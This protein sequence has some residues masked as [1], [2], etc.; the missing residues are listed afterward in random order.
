MVAIGNY[1]DLDRLST[2]TLD[3][4]SHDVRN[5]SSVTNNSDQAV[6]LVNSYEKSTTKYQ[7]VG[8]SLV[9]TYLGSNGVSLVSTNL[10]SCDIFQFSYYQRNPTNSFLFITNSSAAQVKL[11]SVS[12]RCSRH[13][14]NSTLNTES[15]QT[16]NV[17]QRN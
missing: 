17:V 11:I 7:I 10:K 13:V 15:V 8:T 16:A 2:H 12:W 9:R 14:I 5:A 4:F 6:T 1:D 3:Q